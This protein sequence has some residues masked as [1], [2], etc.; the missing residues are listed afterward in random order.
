MRRWLDRQDHYLEKAPPGCLICVAVVDGLRLQGLLLVGR[1]TARALPQDGSWGEISRLWLKPGLPHGTASACIRFA[2]DAC[3]ER[4]MV[5]LI[6]YH[7]RTRHTGC[8]YKKAGMRKVTD[9]TANG[10][11]NRPKR[12]LPLFGLVE[13]RQSGELGGQS[14]R[15]WVID[16]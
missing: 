10:W 3:R 8:I 2:I 5:R 11:S 16:L 7:D 15:R 9:P 1:P 4:G 12:D 14:K 6:S 13:E